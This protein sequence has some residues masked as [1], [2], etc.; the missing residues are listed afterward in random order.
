MREMKDSGIAWI[1]AIP[2][3]WR[4]SKIK[5]IVRWKSVKGQPDLPVLSLYRDYGVIPKDSRDDNHNVTSL[6]T[7]G[8]KVV[9]HGDLVINKM[10]A[11]QGS[12]AVSEYNGIVSPAYHICKITSENICKKYLHYLLRDAS[13]LPEY[14]R[15]STGLRVGQWDLSFDDFK[16]IPFLVPSLAEQER[17]AAFLDAECAEIDTVLEKTRASIEEYKKLKQAVITQA[18]TKGIRGDRPMKDSG[19]EWIGD[20]PAE[21]DVLNLVA[22]TSMLTPMRDRP[23]NL[24]GPIPWVRI[25]DFE[26]KYIESSKA[27]L[28]VSMKTVKE[29][30]LKVYPVGTILCTSSCIM[31]KCAIVSRELVSNQR[32]I[33]IIPDRTT[34]KT[35]LY[36]LMTSN[37]ERMNFLSTGALQANLSRSAFEHLKVQFPPYSEQREIAAYLDDKCEKIDELIL[38]KQQYLTEIENYKK[39]LIYEYVT[40]KK[41]VKTSVLAD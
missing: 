30:N 29:M 6:D 4:V 35:Y 27:G 40:G 22:H 33:G 21:W 25:E 8:Y 7:S 17:I 2:N 16:N 39:S 20:I 11:W 41:E 15:L 37:A 1:G 5:Q 32:F 19:I 26:G 34:D 38:K 12:L 10:K 18:V 23:E 13:Y 31:G 9:E 14:M 3:H 28:G 24:D 36:Y